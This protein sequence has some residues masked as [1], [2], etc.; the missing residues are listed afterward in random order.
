MVLF[1]S[2]SQWMLPWQGKEGGEKACGFEGPLKR[3]L[4]DI[5]DTEERYP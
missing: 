1:D 4:M 2:S 5:V 3:T